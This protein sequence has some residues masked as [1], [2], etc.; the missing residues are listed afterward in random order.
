VCHSGDLHKRCIDVDEGLAGI[1]ACA[2]D[3][4]TVQNPSHQDARP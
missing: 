3:A 4:D 2:S 1:G